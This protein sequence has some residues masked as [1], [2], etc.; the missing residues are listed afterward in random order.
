[1]NPTETWCL[2]GQLADR[3][4][5]QF[6]S[7]NDSINVVDSIGTSITTGRLVSSKYKNVFNQSDICCWFDWL[8][9]A[10]LNCQGHHKSDDGNRIYE[11]DINATPTQLSYSIKT[12]YDIDWP[13][14]QV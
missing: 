14:I 2:R 9:Y 1:M 8:L 5:E 10:L 7:L 12:W 3:T 13:L 4:R 11:V 6:T